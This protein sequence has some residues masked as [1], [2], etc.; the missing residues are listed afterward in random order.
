MS[1]LLWYILCPF[2]VTFIKYLYLWQSHFSF[3]WQIFSILTIKNWFL[4]AWCNSC[5][6]FSGLKWLKSIF[7]YHKQD[8]CFKATKQ[9]RQQT[10]LTTSVSPLIIQLQSKL[11]D[12][13]VELFLQT[14]S[15]SHPKLI[16]RASWE[17][18]KSIKSIKYR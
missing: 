16:K 10:H 13:N 12:T 7:V 18:T 14:S 1:P 2:S 8:K 4:Y 15:L 17:T 11:I 3:L 5:L 6:M 9:K